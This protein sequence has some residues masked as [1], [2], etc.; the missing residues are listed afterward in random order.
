M[1]SEIIAF[2]NEFVKNKEYEKYVTNKY[3]TKKIAILSCMDTR[4]TMLLPAALGL[5]NGDVKIIKNA[6]GVISHPFGS[7]LRSL[8]IAVYE[9]GVEEIMVIGHKDCGMQGLNSE[10]LLHK[11]EERGIPQENVDIIKNCGIDIDG[12][13]SGFECAE[14]S[15]KET[16]NTIKKHPLIPND[17]KIYGFMIDPVTGELEQII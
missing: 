9:Q 11:M 7:V 10:R 16:V 13:L 2:N 8:I 3:P 12:W 14:I 6:G 15:V 1:V 4:L 5:K 17:C